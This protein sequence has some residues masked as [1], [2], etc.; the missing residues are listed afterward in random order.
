MQWNCWMELL[1]LSRRRSRRRSLKRT[2][3]LPAP[4]SLPQ[5]AWSTSA[6]CNAPPPAPCCN[7][8]QECELQHNYALIYILNYNTIRKNNNN[9]IYL[10]MGSTVQRTYLA[11]FTWYS[12]GMVHCLIDEN[13]RWHNMASLDVIIT[14]P[15]AHLHDVDVVHVRHFHVG[16][17]AS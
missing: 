7:N 5:Q 16:R 10:S 15:R 8:D 2:C 3:W 13:P 4:A 17:T 14:K 11:K 12:T 1:V 9:T 6:R